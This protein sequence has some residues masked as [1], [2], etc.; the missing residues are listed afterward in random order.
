VQVAIA[1]HKLAD[2]HLKIGHDPVSARQALDQICARVPGTHLDKMARQRISQLPATR[3][4]LEERERGRPLRLP[5]LPDEIQMPAAPMLSPD[6]ATTDAKA[7]VEAL[8][9][10]P[11]DAPAREKFARLLAENLGD[12]DRAIEQLQLLLA[13]SGQLPA[14]R[15]E[16]LLTIAGWH[17]RY[18]NDF[19]EAKLIYQEVMRDFRHTPHAFSAQRRINLINVQAQFRKRFAERARASI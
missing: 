4:E 7:L 8:K 13:M 11:D 3:E 10:N 18:R 9:K 14:K 17:A 15:A 5:H 1:L 16:W 12:A 2:W 19:E 6:Q